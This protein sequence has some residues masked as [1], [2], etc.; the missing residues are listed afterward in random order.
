MHFFRLPFPPL[1]ST[2]NQPRSPKSLMT[3]HLF[4][5]LDSSLAS[6]PVSGIEPE[7]Y[8]QIK[9][10]EYLA[11]VNFVPV[12]QNGWGAAGIW[13]QARKSQPRQAIAPL[14]DALHSSLGL[15]FWGCAG[16]GEFQKGYST[17]RIPWAIHI[18]KTEY[19]LIE[20]TVFWIHSHGKHLCERT[21]LWW[22]KPFEG[23][24]LF[25]ASGWVCT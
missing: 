18:I 20:Q 25:R 12:G 3:C 10:K 22:S 14:G 2:Y 7:I 15:F 1:G 24:G 8:W 11:H 17:Q 16:S 23:I 9:V 13:L 4:H 5:W 19:D 21:D 6:K